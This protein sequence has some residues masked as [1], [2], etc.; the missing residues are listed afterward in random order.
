M[1]FQLHVAV[2]VPGLTESRGLKGGDS[3]AFSIFFG[4][5]SA[6]GAIICPDGYLVID[7]GVVDF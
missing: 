1:V 3:R 2:V 5:T 4:V 7:V 6:E